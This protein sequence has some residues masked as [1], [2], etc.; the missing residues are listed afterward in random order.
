MKPTEITDLL[1][2]KYLQDQCTPEEKEMVQKW[3]ASLQGHPDYLSTLDQETR[4]KLKEELYID[5]QL[6]TMVTPIVTNKKSVSK[7]WF[8][9]AAAS[10][11]IGMIGSYYVLTSYGLT[12]PETN[13]ITI[14]SQE[15]QSISF[16]ND[17]TKM[18]LHTLPDSSTV[19]M[20]PDS[21]IDY[22]ADFESDSR[23]VTFSGEGFFDVK[24]DPLRPFSIVTGEM[25][26]R[27]LG[28]SFNVKAPTS[29]K[30]TQ[31][32]VMTGSVQVSA[33]TTTEKEQMV[34]LAPQQHAVFEHQSKLLLVKTNPVPGRKEIYEPVSVHFVDQPLS[35]VLDVLEKKFNVNI[36][37]SEHRLEQCVFNGDFE[38]QPLS[39]ILEML[40]ISLE[41]NYTIS[42]NII[43]ISGTPCE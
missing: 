23:R 4:N 18:V 3:Y 10:I 11:L 13:E 26:I 14:D 22:P 27:V 42:D 12:M 34:V 19:W 38:N 29:T 6:K 21:R 31:V 30:L 17:N 37:L 16:V 20:H 1:L 8:T 2:E 24:K 43:L 32:S 15:N 9:V 28:T 7:W 25:T 36:Q 39:A 40:C 5:I 41:A 33:P 35:R